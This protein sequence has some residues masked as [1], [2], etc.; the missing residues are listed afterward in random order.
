M[1]IHLAG[2][3]GGAG[4]PPPRGAPPLPPQGRQLHP[5]AITSDSTG[6]ALD[7]IRHAILSL[8]HFAEITTDDQELAKVHKCITALQ[9]ILADHAAGRD[10]A[11][12]TTP[13]LKHVR[14]S[15]QG[16]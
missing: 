14:R 5:G 1:T 7:F 8:Q 6:G 9:S 4:G 13:A 12:G 11:M 3:L 16:Y 2:L 15:T 10:A